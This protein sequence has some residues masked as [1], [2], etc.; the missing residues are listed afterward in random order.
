MTDEPHIIKARKLAV[1]AERGATAG[2]RAAAAAALEKHLQR[3]GI[4]HSDLADSTRREVLIEC[5]FNVNDPKPN[6]ELAKLSLGLA[7]YIVGTKDVGF[8]L[9]V[10]TVSLPPRRRGGKPRRRQYHVLAVEVTAAEERDLREAIRHYSPM[11]ETALKRL[12]REV[13]LAN[14]ALKEAASAL[15]NKY[16]IFPPDTEISKARMSA[17]A[18]YAHQAAQAATQGEAWRKKSGYLPGSTFLL[19]A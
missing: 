11:L 9:F 5:L 6:L 7:R 2:E 13:R 10:K 18:A 8:Q 19:E 14:A 17:A 3:T 4:T 15:A 1:L 12:R 16:D